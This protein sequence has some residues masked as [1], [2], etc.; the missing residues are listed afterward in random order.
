M[1]EDDPLYELEEILGISQNRY[2]IL[3]PLDADGDRKVKPLTFDEFQEY[4]SNLSGENH[5]EIYEKEHRVAKT[6]LGS[7]TVRTV[8]LFLNH[9]FVPGRDLWFETMVFSDHDHPWDQYQ[10]RY[11]TYKEALAG[12]EAT[13]QVIESGLTPEDF[14]GL[15]PEDF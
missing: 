11:T 1:N 15:T 4:L 12:H 9:G 14:C 7:C 6:E 3:L 2:S 8:H 10:A 5:T 13:C